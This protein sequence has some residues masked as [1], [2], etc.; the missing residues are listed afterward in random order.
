MSHTWRERTCRLLVTPR[1]GTRASRRDAPALAVPQATR[2][3]MQPVQIHLPSVVVGAGALG[4]TLGLLGMAHQISDPPPPKGHGVRPPPSK[5][6][7]L[8]SHVS[9]VYID[10]GQGGQAKTIRFTG[11]NIQIVNGLGATNGNPADP[12]SLDMTATN[13]VGNVIVG[14][15]ELGATSNRTGS[16]CIVTGRGNDYSSFSG[17]LAGS[18]NSIAAPYASVSAGSENRALAAYSTINAGHFNEI[19]IN[20]IYSAINGGTGGRI[21]YVAPTATG[22]FSTICGGA[23]NLI[24]GASTS[25]AV[26]GST[27][28]CRFGGSIVAVGGS[29]NVVEGDA[30]VVVGGN[31]NCVLQNTGSG[32]RGQGS[33]IVGGRDNEIQG[34]ES[35]VCGGQRNVIG[36]FSSLSVIAGGNTNSIGDT[37]TR[38]VVCGGRDRSTSG[39]DDWRAGGL[40]QED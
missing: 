3:P 5:L 40:F 13:S 35:T 32:F 34:Q 21:H 30:A 23:G 7:D 2:S 16:H 8:L 27:N 11:V 12:A 18:Q 38:A 39:P 20:A 6:K 10:D 33:V 14:Y 26:G 9:I 15:N 17:V 36:T 19:D 31:S 24:A 37:S 1:P 29:G 25:V 4:L 28:S 22:S